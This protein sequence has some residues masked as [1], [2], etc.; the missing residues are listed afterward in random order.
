M[1][2][3]IITENNIVSFKTKLNNLLKYLNDCNVSI[4]N[5][6]TFKYIA[7]VYWK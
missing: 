3:E 6:D 2:C 7:C 4:T 1:K 5:N